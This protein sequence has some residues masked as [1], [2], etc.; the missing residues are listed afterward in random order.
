[1]NMAG[2]GR[3]A[4]I[5][6]TPTAG[7]QIT[8]HQQGQGHSHDTSETRFIRVPSFENKNYLALH[9]PPYLKGHAFTL[10]D[11]G[12]DRGRGV[13]KEHPTLTSKGPAN[14]NTDNITEYK[15]EGVIKENPALTPN[16]GNNS[17]NSHVTNKLHKLGDG[18]GRKGT[19]FD[20]N[21]M[22][23]Q[24]L[25]NMSKMYD[26]IVNKGIT[27]KHALKTAGGEK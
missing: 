4:K 22:V 8:S 3:A 21:L 5:S 18:K 6:Y 12:I 15:G 20:N 13:I 27:L 24:N 26:E 1:M 2:E 23:Q 10:K 19:Y 9:T 14:V 7:H 17:N 11:M 16:N 25:T